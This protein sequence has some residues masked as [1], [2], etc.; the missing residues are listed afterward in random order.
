L[1]ALINQSI[2]KPVG[3]VNPL[4]YQDA[5]TARDLSDITSGTNGAYSAGR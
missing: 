5:G 1:I 4:L 2:G 3:F